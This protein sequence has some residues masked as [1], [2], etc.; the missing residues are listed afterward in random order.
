MSLSFN[1]GL[2]AST[3]KGE[4]CWPPA[5]PNMSSQVKLPLGRAIQVDDTSLIHSDANRNSD[6]TCLANE[7]LAA[8]EILSTKHEHDFTL[9]P[10]KFYINFFSSVA[11][12]ITNLCRPLFCCLLY[13]CLLVAIFVYT[14]DCCRVS[15][16]GPAKSSK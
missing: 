13:I 5:S 16:E 9:H 15:V 11:H 2:P 10:Y 12:L 7:Q 4:C 8:M 1:S 6:Y 3:M 14:R